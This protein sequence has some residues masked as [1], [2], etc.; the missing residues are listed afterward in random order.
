MIHQ[1]SAEHLTIER[2][3]EIIRNGYKIELS[4]DARQRIIRCRK[5]LDEKIERESEPIYGV[6]TGFGSLCK[7]SIG[8]DQLSELQVN[9]IMSHAC[10]V[11]ERVPNDIVKI[12]ILLK[13]QN[14]SYGYSGC[15]LDT[16]KRMIDF[17]NNDVYPIVYMQGSLGASGDL[18]PLA[19]LCLPMLGMG[20]VEYQEQRM[21]GADLLKKMN[22]LPIKLASK[23]GLALLNGTQNMAAFA[24]WALINAQRLS[25]WADKISAMSLEAFDGRIDPFIHAVHVLRPHKGQIETADYIRQLLEGSELIKQPKVN[26]QDPYSFR[27]IPQVHG[28]VK[29]TIHYVYSVI[30]REIN[31]VTDNPIVCEN[32]DAVISAGNF[33]GEPIAMPLDFLCIALSELANIS[34][35]RIYRLVSGTRGLPSFL[36]ANPGVNSGFMITQYTAAAV[37]SQSKTLGMPASVDSIPSSQDQE[38]HVSMGANAATKLYK[39]VY[40]TEKVL[41]IELFNAAQALD[42]RRPLKSSPAIE[43]IYEEYRKIVPF[44]KED[45]VMYTH[46]AHSIEFLR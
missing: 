12:M 20:E 45:Q 36:V 27:C 18:V 37:V 10:G 23:E 2:I 35:R 16:V 25:T 28:A 46:I 11:G 24:V 26:V 30:D 13:I 5:Y 44:L 39:V 31:S 32:E 3:D 15:K 8:A 4:E 1:I 19:H 14:M 7:V 21:T 33:H 41:A 29:D 17:F 43:A 34:E 42:F 6:T 9:L 40:N 38:D 22:W